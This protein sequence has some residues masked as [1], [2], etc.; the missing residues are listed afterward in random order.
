MTDMR[1]DLEG[2]DPAALQAW[3]DELADV[4]SNPNV[5]ST[6]EQQPGGVIQYVLRGQDVCEVSNTLATNLIETG[7]QL[8]TKDLQQLQPPECTPDGLRHLAVL[9]HARETLGEDTLEHLHSI[10]NR[11]LQAH[12]N[13]HAKT[14]PVFEHLVDRANAGEIRIM[15]CQAPCYAK[16][17]AL[18]MLADNYLQD[19]VERQ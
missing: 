14:I 5:S 16:T 17:M 19:M 11:V 1:V 3:L 18:G 2:S 15:C 9:A 10:Y 13:D 7:A 12:D 8:S 4:R 6:I